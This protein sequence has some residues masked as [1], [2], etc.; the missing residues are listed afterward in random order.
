MFHPK[1]GLGVGGGVGDGVVVVVGVGGI[2]LSSFPS[3]DNEIYFSGRNSHSELEYRW[4]RLYGLPPISEKKIFYTALITDK[5]AIRTVELGNSS[6]CVKSAV[7]S[8]PAPSA[9]PQK[10]KKSI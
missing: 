7:E 5:G 3:S 9:P 8:Y 10:K 6:A 2:F 1:S 4:I